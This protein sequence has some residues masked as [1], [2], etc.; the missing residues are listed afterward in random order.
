MIRGMHCA[1]CVQKIETALKALP[2]IEEVKVNFASTLTHV[3]GTAPKG[4]IDKVI[5]SLGYH[6]A[7]LKEATHKKSIPKE[8]R[9]R[10]IVAAVLTLPVFYLGMIA[11][12][13]D[14]YILGSEW[15]QFILTTIIL[16]YAGRQF[17]ISAW[18]S[19]KRMSA[20]M[21]TLIALGSGAAYVYSFSAL[22]QGIF[23]SDLL[24]FYFDSAAMIITLILFGN[25]LESRSKSETN[26]AVQKIL[27]L[28]PITARVIRND[29]EVTL[30]IDEL[31][32]GDICVVLSG[33]KIPSD[34]V[35]I[36]GQSSV[37]E[38]M[39]TGESLPVSKQAGDTVV[40]VT[41]NGEG[42][43]K[44]KIEKIGNDTVF[45]QIVQLVEKIQ[46]T[47]AP[48]QRL[49]D[50]VASYFVPA[51]LGIATLTVI[52]WGLLAGQFTAGLFAAITV[53]VI[54]CPCALGLATPTAIVVGSG[55]AAREGILFK[56]A[57]VLETLGK[58]DTIVFDKTG[59][60]TSGNLTITQF[61]NL[62]VLSDTEVLEWVASI[63]SKSNHPIA[64][65][66][67]KYAQNS[68]IPI[69]PTIDVKTHPGLGLS[70]TLAGRSFLIGNAT[71][72]K[73][74]DIDLS[75]FGALLPEEKTMAFVAADGALMATF[76]LSDI[77]RDKAKEAIDYLKKNNIE[78]ILMTGDTLG[79]T[80]TL[81]E[82]LD[83][84]T[85]YA[86]LT[87]AE[88]VEKI[89]ELQQSHHV[90]MV[91]DGINDA[92]ALQA[93]DLGIAI[94][95]GTD[96]AIESAKIILVHGDIHKVAEAI[97]IGKATLTTIR[98]NL[99]FAFIYNATMIPVAALGLLNPMIAAACMSASSISVVLN[100]LRLKRLKSIT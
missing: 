59:T 90:A 33:E 19:A 55:K 77:I 27:E 60:L 5:L 62:S 26:T 97:H 88:K 6:P 9:R 29:K 4:E 12:G 67:V 86:Q 57:A 1:S 7:E 20:D 16:A 71:F 13:L 11:P 89:K 54:A 49:A 99:F 32:T 52:L 14:I 58:I 41:L 84:S 18:F 28:K 21:D 38:S 43:L 48:I 40:G 82:S 69:A 78:P 23:S 3:T 53:L 24:P 47:R 79:A 15:I 2:Q 96:I 68:S 61:K 56:E 76:S 74:H 91:G 73:E 81:V 22:I 85:F 8:D 98:Q 35:I 36:E 42:V 80:K 44:I 75:K 64:K 100:A 65:A 66:I 30:S 50:R 34:G 25:Y 87:P 93:A 83:I 37:D 10:L 31:K 46:M 51:V 63:E 92:P 94:G 45:S 39:I 72:M 17:F 70:A 95:T